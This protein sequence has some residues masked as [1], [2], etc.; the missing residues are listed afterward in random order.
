MADSADLIITADLDGSKIATAISKIKEKLQTLNQNVKDFGEGFKEGF[1]EGIQEINASKSLEKTNSGLKKVAKTTK[2]V[3]KEFNDVGKSVGNAKSSLL[4][5]IKAGIG[6]SS[7]AVLFS[8]LKS[9][10][11]DGLQN[12]VQ[13]DGN[14]NK[15]I[16]D[17]IGSLITLKNALASAFA[18]IINIVAPILTKF[19]SMLTAVANKVSYFIALLTGQKTFTMAKEVSYDYAKSLDKTAKSTK[20]A[21]KETQKYLSGLDEITQ[22][23]KEQEELDSDSSGSG[24]GGG[25]IP[26]EMFE[27]GVVGEVPEWLKNALDFIG[28]I[29]TELGKLKDLFK[30]GFFDGLGDWQPRLA[31]IIDNLKKIKEHLKDI[32]T[33]PDVVGSAQTMINKIVY[34]LGQVTGAI[35]SVGLTIAQNLVGGIEKF[36]ADNKDYLKGKLIEIFD[37]TGEIAEKVG[38]FAETVARIFEVFG[39]ENGQQLT[40]NIIGIFSSAFLEILTLAGKFARDVIDAIT[41]PITDNEDEITTAL[42]NTLGALADLSGTALQAIQDLGAKLDETYD[43]HVK[44]FI[45][46]CGDQF[47]KLVKQVTDWYNND[48]MP[49]FNDFKDDLKKD[50]DEKIKPTLDGICESLGALFDALDKFIQLAEPFYKKVMEKELDAL[51]AKVETT[52]KFIED[53]ID[54][55]CTA[56]NLLSDTFTG[57]LKVMMA[58]MNGDFKTAMEEWKTMVDNQLEDVKLLFESAFNFIKDML[59]R[60]ITTSPIFSL[61]LKLSGKSS[62]SSDYSSGYNGMPSDIPQLA[63]GAVIPPNAPFMAMLGDQTSGN[64]IEAP[65]SLIRQAVREESGRNGSYQFTAQINRR[66]L[67]DELISEGKL[68]QIST[69]RNPFSFA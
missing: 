20:K 10:V 7:L 15:S 24:S 69:G 9:A 13:Y 49:V 57:G 5:F 64:N 19:I 27:T 65:E 55:M 3:K 36:L 16:S 29:K 23:K 8:K 52:C 45:D 41:K 63:T 39:D 62:G 58:L 67:F 51:K 40:A 12:L 37:V 25:L 68:R 26:T 53:D 31:N 56:I 47:S 1:A 21:T 38:N 48:L 28:K 6:I 60:K 18:P 30:A 61:A 50:Y 17:L 14:T 66:V 2:E 4:K 54:L 11:K 42:D 35:A 46:D 34:A 43:E 33:D 32:F 44:P 59:E 22:W